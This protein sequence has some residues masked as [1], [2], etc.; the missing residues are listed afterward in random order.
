MRRSRSLGW[1]G[2]SC[3]LP[4]SSGAVAHARIV[5]AVIHTYIFDLLDALIA[6]IICTLLKYYEKSSCMTSFRHC[7]RIQATYMPASAL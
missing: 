1:R 7:K 3:S 2:P 6:G 5:P 4:G